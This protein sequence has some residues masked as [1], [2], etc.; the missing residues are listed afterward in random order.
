MTDYPLVTV[1]TSARKTSSSYTTGDT[2][3][4]LTYFLFVLPVLIVILAVTFYPAAYNVF[5]SF[6][7][8]ACAIPRPNLSE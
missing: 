5:I 3:T 4:W 7:T 8:R 2:G 1:N 6:A